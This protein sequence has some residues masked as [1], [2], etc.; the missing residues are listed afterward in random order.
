MK[1]RGNAVSEARTSFE[2][3]ESMK[4]FFSREDYNM[5]RNKTPH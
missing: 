4:N 1:R 2:E 3:G 5:Q